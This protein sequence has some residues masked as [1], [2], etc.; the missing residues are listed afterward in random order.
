M[1]DMVLD[2]PHCASERTGFAFGGELADEPPWEGPMWNTLFV[3][4]KCRSG[5]VARLKGPRTGPKPSAC[6]GDPSDEGFE[7][8]AVH[9][10]PQPLNI[11]AHLPEEI[12]GDYREAADSLRRRNDTAAG[13]VF[14]KVLQRTTTALA[15][16]GVTGFRNKRLQDRIDTLAG[17][18]LITPAMCEWAHQIRDDGNE[19]NHEEDVVFEQSDAEQI[20]AFTELFLIYAFTLPERV[21]LARGTDTDEDA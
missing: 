1:A 17:H 19:A 4:R 3:C 16:E 11:P 9:P 20:Q 5:V 21:R 13:M 18:R 2:C 6:Q 7:V 15:P 10:K 14:R 8:L 12:A